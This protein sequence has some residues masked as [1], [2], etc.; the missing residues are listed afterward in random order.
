[1][2]INNR[3]T[4]EKQ[5]QHVVQPQ[6]TL[7]ILNLS[8]SHFYNNQHSYWQ[9]YNGNEITSIRISFQENSTILSFHVHM[10]YCF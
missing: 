8:V 3:K 6:H 7:V 1:M 10:K 5:V 9:S 4:T 2:K